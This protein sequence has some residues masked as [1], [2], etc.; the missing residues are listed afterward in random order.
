MEASENFDDPVTKQAWLDRQKENVK[1]YLSEERIKFTNEPE[2][3]WFLAPY[4]SVWHIKPDLWIIS[5]DLPTDYIHDK[6]I[7]S[8]TEAVK[9][10][11]TRWLE[12]STYLLKGKQHPQLPIGKTQKAEEL[13]EMG[14]LLQSRAKLFLKWIDEKIIGKE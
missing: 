2:V 3:N 9:Y 6:S 14:S 8:V 1:G 10:F 13:K 4:I 12:I 5:G 7:L 11:A